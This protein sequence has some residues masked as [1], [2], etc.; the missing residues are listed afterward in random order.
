M[1]ISS[2]LWVSATVAAVGLGSAAVGLPGQAVAAS[3]VARVAD[4]V[5]SY[6]STANL[7]GHADGSSMV[8][9]SVYLQGRSSAALGSLLR[10]LQDPHSARYHQFL[11]AVQFRQQFAPAPADASAVQQWL[12]K[13]GFVIGHTPANRA[14]VDAT[15]TVSQVEQTFGV[16]EN[17]YRVEGHTV[18]GNAQ[19]PAVPSDLASS[20]SFVGGLDDSDF[21]AK[22]SNTSAGKPAAG[23]GVGYSTPGPCSTYAGDHP[24]TV[25]PPAHQYGSN[26]SWT[27]CGYDPFQV[28]VAYGL[29]GNYSTGD[30]LT[31][32]GIRIGITDAFASPTIQADLDQYSLNHGLPLTKIEQHVTPG[33]YRFPENRFD[34]QGWYGEESLDVDAAHSIAPEATLV[35]EGGNN[36][37]E[38]LDHALIDM[39][40]NHRADIITNSWGING[41]PKT[42]GSFHNTEAALQQAAATGISVLFSSGDTGDVA[43]ETGLAQSSWPASSPYATAVG[44]T[45]LLLTSASGSKSEFGWGTYKSNLVNAVISPPATGTTVT[46]DGYSPWP[47]AFLYG[48]GGGLSRIFAQPPYQVGKV[49]GLGTST[50]TASGTPVTYSQPRRVVPDVSM[51]GDPNTGLLYGQTYDVSGDPLIDAGCT[52]VAGNREYCERRIGGTSLSSP[53]FAGVLALVDQARLDNGDGLLGFANPALYSLSSGLVDVLAPAAPTAVLRNAEVTPTSLQTSV[54]TINSV[55]QSVNGPVIEGADT[56]LRTTAGYDN[57]TGLGTPDIPGLVAALS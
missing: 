31:G 15:G 28:R 25:T 45:S 33:I 34:P 38:P 14:Y 56:S 3:G 46:A 30:A 36:S 2:R 26:L 21:F 6:A 11:S 10:D 18:R 17:T 44:G 41:D 29:P 51:V 43:A 8:T 27:P 9:V 23:P 4:N 48:S 12:K 42:F 1:R 22:P 55:P 54:R 39:I 32:R 50:V 20:V 7:T 57:V 49:N 35:Y 40:D 37:N 52:P 13:A 5:P 47:P 19:A 16:T 24:A 53:L